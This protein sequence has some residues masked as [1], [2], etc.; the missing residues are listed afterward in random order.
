MALIWACMGVSM[1]YGID[2]GLY[3]TDVAYGIVLGVMALILACM[4][5][6]MA[7]G[8]VTL[9]RESYV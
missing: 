9:L 7:Y 2:L 6:S 1:A 5:V 4:G 3:G 8:C